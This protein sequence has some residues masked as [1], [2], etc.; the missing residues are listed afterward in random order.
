MF[1]ML[2]LKLVSVSQVLWEQM[3][4]IVVGLEEHCPMFAS[5]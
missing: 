2:L 3:S 5:K 1:Q 4:V